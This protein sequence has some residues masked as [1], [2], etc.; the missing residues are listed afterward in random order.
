MTKTDTEIVKV[1]N[2]IIRNTS[3]RGVGGG[4]GLDHYSQGLLKG[5]DLV[6][7]EIRKEIRK[8]KQR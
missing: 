7:L 3:T 4:G 2:R 8:I 6:R 1:L 5:R